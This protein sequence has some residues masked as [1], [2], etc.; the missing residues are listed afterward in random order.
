[1]CEWRSSKGV[2]GLTL[3]ELGYI[4]EGAGISGRVQWTHPN[5]T[6][7]ARSLTATLEGQSGIGSVAT[8]EEKL[9]RGSLTLTQPYIHV[10]QLSL[11]IG[12]FSEY[13]DD[14]RDRSV[15]VG[16]SGIF[17][18]RLA[19]LSTIALEYRYEASHIYEYRF[20][21]SSDGT[22]SLARLLALNNPALQDSLGPGYRQEL[23]DVDRLVRQ[24]RQPG[25]S[26]KGLVH[27]PSGGDHGPV[28]D[29][30]PCSSDDWT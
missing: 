22:I 25:Q 26:S 13:R 3:A 30:A 10:P 20:G 11:G 17:L 27:P 18:Y 19:S 21:T 28:R 7:G 12:P 16:V 6:G 29:H 15:S 9:L 24:S 23:G 8:Q 14:L 4:S 2:L 1:M 5:F